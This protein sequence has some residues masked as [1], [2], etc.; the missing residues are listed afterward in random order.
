MLA[1]VM[2]S[3]AGTLAGIALLIWVPS[4]QGLAGWIFTASMGVSAVSWWQAL[5]PPRRRSARPLRLVAAGAITS[6]AGLVT[7]L[8]ISIWWPSH[9]GLGSAFLASAMTVSLIFWWQASRRPR[10]QVQ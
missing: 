9:D 1:A 7:N 6:G 4:D 10:R 3:G 8:A 2:C 5:R